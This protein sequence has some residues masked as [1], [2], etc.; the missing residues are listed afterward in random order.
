[1][2]RGGGK[3]VLVSAIACA[4]VDVDGPLV[5]PMAETLVVGSSFEMT[6]S[7]R[8]VQNLQFASFAP[9]MA[10]ASRAEEGCSVVEGVACTPG[11]V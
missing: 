5:A 6:R 4:T 2:G 1:M 10:P 3:T 8:S 7:P 11:R 9:F